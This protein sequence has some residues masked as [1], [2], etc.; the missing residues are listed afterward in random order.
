MIYGS[1][2]LLM[3]KKILAIAV[4]SLIS[5]RQSAPPL[6]NHLHVTVINLWIDQYLCD[7]IRSSN[8][9]RTFSLT[10]F[11]NHTRLTIFA[12]LSI[13]V[14]VQQFFLSTCDLE[15]KRQKEPKVKLRATACLQSQ[16]MLKSH[17]D[18]ILPRSRGGQL[19]KI[20]ID[21]PI[22]SPKIYQSP[23][24]GLK[25]V[26][27]PGNITNGNDVFGPQSKETMIKFLVLF[28]V[29]DNHSVY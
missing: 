8:A 11:D 6:T 21:S 25:L 23:T 22:C 28:A 1:M 18:R 3:L 4:M 13:H 26:K 27:V 19:V 7:L 14:F 10:S 2:N 5:I 9:Q 15:R 12:K 29:A 20:T 16:S 17:T 24:T